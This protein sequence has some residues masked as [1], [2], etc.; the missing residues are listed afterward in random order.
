MCAQWIS[1]AKVNV[2][3]A[4]MHSAAVRRPASVLFHTACREQLPCNS[5]IL[6]GSSYP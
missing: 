2:V 3:S 1:F 5:E 4:T 6:S